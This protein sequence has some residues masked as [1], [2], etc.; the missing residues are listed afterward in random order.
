MKIEGHTFVITGGASGL[1]E[2]LR[3]SYDE[4]KRK[5]TV[6]QDSI[7]TAHRLRVLV[8][9]GVRHRV[10]RGPNWHRDQSRSWYGENEVGQCNGLPAQKDGEKRGWVVQVTGRTTAL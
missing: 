1:G 2:I 3:V 10:A 9:I 5:S 4:E 6:A 7:R 8:I